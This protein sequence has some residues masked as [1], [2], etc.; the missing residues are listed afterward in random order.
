M[1]QLLE[2]EGVVRVRVGV[3]ELVAARRV[4]E[5]LVGD[6]P[7]TAVPGDEGWLSVRMEAG[8]AAEVNRALAL[9]GIYASGLETGSD[10]ESLF[11]SL[12]AGSQ[13]ESHEGTFFGLAGSSAPPAG[14]TGWHDGGS[15]T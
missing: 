7:V 14:P 10:L 3:G 11:L 13:T 1:D 12:T 2:G 15:A 4:L 6:G 8:R 5:G 9:A